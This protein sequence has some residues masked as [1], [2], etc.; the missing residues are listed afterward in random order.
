MKIT[1]Q[2]LALALVCLLFPVTGAPAAE[3]PPMKLVPG[4]AFTI[5]FPELPPPFYA[6]YQNKDVKTRMTVFLPRNYDP[7]R[8]HPLLIFLGGGD[9]GDAGNPGV[10]RA[11]SEERD[12]ICVALPLFREKVPPK[13]PGNDRAR[14]LLQEADAKYAWPFYKQMLAKLEAAVPNI[15]PARRVLGGFSNGAHMTAYL[16][17]QTDGEAAARFSAFI[18]GDGGGGLKRFD[19]LKGKPLLEVCGLW[20]P[21]PEKANEAGVKLTIHIMA[22]RKHAF[23]ASEYPV[24]RAWLRGAIK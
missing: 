22:E 21:K 20:R 4:A 1:L 6:L 5:P 7:A 24:V 11:L 15:D 10:A 14:I 16:I 19:L 3:A 9:G 18:L 13:E 2:S 17:N 8:K 12:F 23:P